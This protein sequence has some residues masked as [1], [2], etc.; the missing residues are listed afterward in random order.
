MRDSLDLFKTEQFAE[1]TL[2]ARS[3]RCDFCLKW[4]GI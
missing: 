4:R 3:N 1:T 2:F